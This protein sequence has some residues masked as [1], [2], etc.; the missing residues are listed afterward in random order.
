MGIGNQSPGCVPNS[1]PGAYELGDRQMTRTERLLRLARMRGDRAAIAI[2][3][4][5][6]RKSW[7]EWT[8]AELREAWGR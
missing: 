5:R 4:G 6:L 8:E 3:E 7:R 2:L 1:A